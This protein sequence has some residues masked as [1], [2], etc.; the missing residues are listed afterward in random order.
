MKVVLVGTE[1]PLWEKYC[2]NMQGQQQALDLMGIDYKFIDCRARLSWAK[3]VIQYEP[4][5]VVYL[6][7]DA[8]ISNDDAYQVK[9]QLPDVK[10]VMWY[11]D[12]RDERTGGIPHI[13]FTDVLDRFF[14]SNDGQHRFWKAMV[15]LEGEYLPLACDYK[16]EREYDERYAYDVV[17]I[18]G[19]YR[20]VLGR[21]TKLLNKIMEEIDVKQINEESPKRRALV[22]KNM[23]KIYGSSKISLD[24]SN[25]WDIPGYTSNRGFIIPMYSGFSLSKRFPGCEDLFEDEKHKVYFDTAEDA[26]DKIKYYLNNKEEREKIREAG[27]KH[28]LANHTY[29]ERFKT[30]F[31]KLGLKW[32]Q[33]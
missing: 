9:R 32:K 13:D 20:G 28:A 19:M 12:L 8:L 6:L 26:I 15:G 16:V 17:F 2:P 14:V 24:V 25:F 4:D 10:T 7:M 5:L 33:K 1:I 22:Y 11:G 3:D 29:I 23:P 30:M 21:R 18:G 27:H 31:N